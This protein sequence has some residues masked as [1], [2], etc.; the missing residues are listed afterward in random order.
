MSISVTLIWI[1]R[2]DDI[3]LV[4]DFMAVLSACKS[5]KDSIKNEMKWNESLS[6]GQHFPK[7]KRPSRAGNYHTN[8]QNWAKI[9]LV[10]DVMSVLLSGMMKSHLKM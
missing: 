4:Q 10:G 5:D 9:I 6:P 1:V 3:E 2:S 8:S 7:F